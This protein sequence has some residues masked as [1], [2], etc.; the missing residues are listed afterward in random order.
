M[1]HSVG[2]NAD[3][4]FIEKVNGRKRHCVQCKKVGNGLQVDDQSRAPSSVFSALWHSAKLTAFIVFIQVDY[5]MPSRVF[6]QQE[7]DHPKI[8]ILQQYLS[9]LNK[10]N[11]IL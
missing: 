6:N 10:I 1:A 5:L 4:H 9:I 11:K 7:I 3:E 2:D 8:L